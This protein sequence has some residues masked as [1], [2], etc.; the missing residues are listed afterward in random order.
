MILVNVKLGKDLLE[1]LLG[2]EF[3]LIDANHHELLQLDRS[4]AR[5]VSH[6]NQIVDPFLVKI[7]S[8]MLSV[9]IKEFFSWKLAISWCVQVSKHLLQLNLVVNI[10]E[11]LDQV[12]QGCLLGSVLAWERFQVGESARHI[13]FTL[14][15][16][17]PAINFLLK[18]ADHLEPGMLEGLGGAKSVGFFA[19]NPGD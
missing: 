7:C 4:I 1:T 2:Q 12:A 17:C 11:M 14:V 19:Q 9:S 10:E 13:L 16:G 15:K 5:W 18:L 6:W 3:L 8:K